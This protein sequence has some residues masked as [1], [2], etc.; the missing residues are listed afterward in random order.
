MTTLRIE[1]PI[2]DYA[3]WRN[4]FEQAAPFREQAGVR[5]YRIQRPVDDPDYLMIDLDFD[6]VASAETLLSVLRDVIWA[7]PEASPG[8]GGQPQARIAETVEAS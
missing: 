4:A 7:S 6:D 8:L 1:H 5:S 2:T 3:T